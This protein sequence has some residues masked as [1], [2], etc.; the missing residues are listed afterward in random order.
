MQTLR[1]RVF[2]DNNHHSAAVHKNHQPTYNTIANELHQNHE[3]YK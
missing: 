2:T 3:K 1:H